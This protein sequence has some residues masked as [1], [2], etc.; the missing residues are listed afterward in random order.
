M[1][2]QAEDIPAWAE[3]HK[4]G[5]V[6]YLYADPAESGRKPFRDRP[7]ARELMK[8]LKKGDHLVVYE[9]ERLGRGMI[10]VIGTI[11]MLVNNMGVHLHVVHCLGGQALDFSTIHGK[12]AFMG[13]C[14]AAEIHC[15]YV[16][17]R[18][19]EAMRWRRKRGLPTNGE[20]PAGSMIAG[21][22]GKKHFIPDAKEQADIA[23]IWRLRGLGWSINKIW[24]E[25]WKTG[26][27]RSSG[28]EWTFSSIRDILSPRKYKEKQA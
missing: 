28:K 5:K 24:V 20:V 19:K 11:D 23:E 18:T 6:H 10:S 1:Q 9:L 16:S 17:R 22:K 12:L 14:M 7:Q 13:M 3:Q 2:Q 8:V 27:R 15:D 25:F 26:K 4:L 21:D